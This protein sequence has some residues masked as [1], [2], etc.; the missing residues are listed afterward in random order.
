MTSIAVVIGAYQHAKYIGECIES[1]RSQSLSPDQIIVVDDGSTDGTQQVAKAFG[2]AVSLINTNRMGPSVVFNTGIAHA[3]T[4]LVAIVSADD[5]L[6]QDRLER[7]TNLLATVDAQLAVGLPYVIDESGNR[8]ADTLAPEFFPTVTK[9]HPSLTSRLFFEGNFICA[10]TATF[11]RKKFLA[12]GGF[13]PGLLQLQDFEL[14]LRWSSLGPIALSNERC[15][16]YRKT[17]FNL[18]RSENLH[19]MH[20]ERLWIYRHFFDAFDPGD[21]WRLFRLETP[22]KD[23]DDKVLQAVLMLSHED[24]LIQSIGCERLLDVLTSPTG[25]E[26]LKAGGFSLQDV[27]SLMEK[28]SLASIFDDKQIIDENVGLKRLMFKQVSPSE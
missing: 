7:Q 13:H 5:R 14:W 27:F 17:S 26:S 20:A 21:S 16:E 1:V 12:L 18:S 28:F 11:D 6:L 25:I 9:H 3:K 19:R 4:D 15:T 8:R 2:D 10:P 22:W 24:A 23:V